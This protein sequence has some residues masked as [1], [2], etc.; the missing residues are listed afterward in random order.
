M[1]AQLDALAVVVDVVRGRLERDLLLR[2]P[3]VEDHAAGNAVVRGGSATPPGGGDGYCHRAFRVCTELDCHHHLVFR[4]VGSG[5]VVTLGDRV[6]GRAETDGY[7][8]IVVVVDA[9]RRLGDAAGAYLRRQVAETQPDSLSV[10]VQR[11]VGGRE[12]D[13]LLGIVRAEVQ[14]R[15]CSQE[16]GRPHAMQVC[17]AHRDVHRPLGLG[18][19]DDLDRDAVRPRQP[20]RKAPRNSP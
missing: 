7:L 18:R 11:V 3:G 2:V 13:G 6:A 4:G 17:S 16:V 8:R 15:R 5:R 9:H 12:V 14:G 19:Q 10:V 1:E 20:R